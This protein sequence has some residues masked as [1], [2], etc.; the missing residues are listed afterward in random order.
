MRNFQCL[1]H[2]HV[3]PKPRLFATAKTGCAPPA[4]ESLS[5]RSMCVLHFPSNQK[6]ID[7]KEALQRKLGH[8]DFNFQGVCFPD[9]VSFLNFDFNTQADFRRAIFNAQVDFGRA[10]FKAGANFKNATFIGK[11]NFRK[12]SFDKGWEMVSPT[13]VDDMAGKTGSLFKD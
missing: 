4:L 10:T 1:P 3:N 9:E 2:Q 5:T 13:A 8:E 6:G 7:F 11:A 12:A